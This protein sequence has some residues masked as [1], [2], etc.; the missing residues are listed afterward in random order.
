MKGD[1]YMNLKKLR[2][3]RKELKLTQQEIASYFGYT[4]QNYNAKENG[5]Q[6]FKLQEIKALKDMLGFT[7][8]EVVEIFI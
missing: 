3:R 1:T 6:N 5:K 2:D 4:R 7:D 8:S